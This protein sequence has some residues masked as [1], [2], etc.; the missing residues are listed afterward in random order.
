MEKFRVFRVYEQGGTTSG[1]LEMASLDELSVGEVVIRVSY[2]CVNYKDA[3]AATGKGKIIRRFPLIAGVDAAGYVVSS[4]TPALHE[5]D[6]V[7]VTGY[8]LGTG[9]DG[10]YAEYIRVPASWVIPLPD[11]MTTKQA[12]SLGTAA[13]TVALCIKRLE[14]NAQHPNQGKIIVTGASG[15]VGSLAVDILS[16]RGYEVVALSSKPEAHTYLKQLGAKHVLNPTDIEMTDA[17]LAKSQWAGAIDNVGGDIL[18]WLTRTV[19]PWGNIVSVGLAGGSHLNTT[20]MPFILR[21]VNL[22]GVA[23]A[24]CPATWRNRLWQRLASDLAPQ[25]LDRIVKQ[26]SLEDLP[27]IFDK[28]LKGKM[29]GKTLVKIEEK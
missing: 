28:L 21:G 3:L 6:A 1:R 23:S 27:K 14:D 26:V 13:F 4:V 15:G 29:I 9:H 19:K 7:L 8:E 25:H 2:S 16:A 24:A 22:L 10:G 11:G 20:V 17:P 18:A 5:G 12:M